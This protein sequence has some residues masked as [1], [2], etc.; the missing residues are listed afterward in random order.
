MLIRNLETYAPV[1]RELGFQVIP[2]A[3]LTFDGVPYYSAYLDFGPASIDGWLA[4]M[5][6]AELGEKSVELLDRDAREL[7]VD[8]Q[9]VGLTRL[10]FGVMDYLCRNKG[11]VATRAALVAEVW[12]YSDDDGGSNVVDVVI[13]SLRKKLGP[14]AAAIETVTGAGYRLR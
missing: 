12:G 14:H 6:G 7:A 2:E 5:M 11:K 13:R 1:A 10:E 8:G 3:T 4:G 9:R